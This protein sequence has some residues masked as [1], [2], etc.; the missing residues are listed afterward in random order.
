MREFTVGEKEAGIRADKYVMRLLDK[1]PKGFV[2][3]MLRKKNIVLNDRKITGSETLKESDVIKI[4]FSDETFEKFSSFKTYNTFSDNEVKCGKIDI[5]YEDKDIII[6]NKPAGVLSQKADKNDYSANEQIIDYLI[7]SG[8]LKREEL[9][10]FRPS[11]CSRLD[12]NT[13]GLLIAGKTMKGLQETGELIK[14][15]RLQ[16]YYGCIVYGNVSEGAGIQ[17]YLVKDHAS[18]IVRVTRTAYE[19]GGS[20]IETEYKPAENLGDFTFLEVHLITG[21]SHQIRAHLAAEGYPVCGDPKYG[22][23]KINKMLRSKLGIESQML[24]AAKLVFPDG[25]EFCAPE[26]E[27]FARLRDYMA[28][29]G[30]TVL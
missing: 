21:R 13:S 11:V 28:A 23:K 22:N 2:Y 18:N 19:G 9:A 7:S 17:G 27:E 16:K 1:A 25:R 26:P 14:S 30:G 10:V 24:Y 8:Q 20:Y 29:S 5:I 3:K 6:I 15:R 4:Y 12:R